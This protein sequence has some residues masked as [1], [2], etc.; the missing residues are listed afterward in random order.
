MWKF[1]GETQTGQAMSINQ[2]RRLRDGNWDQPKQRDTLGEGRAGNGSNPDN[3]SS[4]Y[5]RY[6]AKQTGEKKGKNYH[7]RT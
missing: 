7:V 3:E 6:I 4:E 1:R 2:V 5:Q